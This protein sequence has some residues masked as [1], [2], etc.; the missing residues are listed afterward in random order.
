MPDIIIESETYEN[1]D[2]ATSLLPVA[3][4]DNCTFVNCNFAEGNLSKT[5]FLECRFEHCN[6]SNAVLK[7]T[8]FKE[9]EFAHCK[10][11]GVDFSNCND[12][13]LEMNFEGC[14]LDLTSFYL[15]TLKGIKFTRCSLKEADFTQTNLT[16]ATFED[17]NLQRA[18][19]DRTTLEKADLKTAQNY[20]ID[21]DNNVITKAKFALDGLP[22][23]LEKH[24][25]SVEGR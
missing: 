7:Q 16:N 22:G 6:L 20:S 18:V 11:V 9:V 10:M 4:Y 24:R 2:Y 12:F 5:S 25:I 23:L 3:E 19:F 14:Q 15:L 21:P 17:C 13:L 8:A 1:I